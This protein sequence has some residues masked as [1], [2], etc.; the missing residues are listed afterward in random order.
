[1]VN[2]GMQS[3]EISY[4]EVH[5]D[6][7]IHIEI[8]DHFGRITPS[9]T[10]DEVVIAKIEAVKAFAEALYYDHFKEVA[11]GRL[12][13]SMDAIATMLDRVHL[14]TFHDN[15]LDPEGRFAAAIRDGGVQMNMESFRGDVD[16][17]DLIDSPA[18][19]YDA[20]TGKPVSARRLRR[21]K[22]QD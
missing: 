16:D 5:L 8:R 1:M 18:V 14:S 17:P 6:I 11:E 9:A 21:L 19:V 13:H 12:E 10:A 3:A 4:P 20:N 15:V 2:Y 22:M 7:R